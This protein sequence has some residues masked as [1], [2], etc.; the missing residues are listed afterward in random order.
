MTILVVQGAT[1]TPNRHLEVQLS[2]STDFR[3]QSGS[4]LGPTLAPF[5]C[6]S[7]ILDTNMG[8]TF[9]VHVLVIQ[10]WKRC[11]NEVPVCA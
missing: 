8:D 10:G 4:L 3:V 1:G 2:I 7:V 5:C 11:Q 9:Q 6:V